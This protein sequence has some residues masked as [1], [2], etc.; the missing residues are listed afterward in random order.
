MPLKNPSPLS[1][2]FFH[3]EWCLWHGTS[4]MFSR[5]LPVGKWVQPPAGAGMADSPE[6]KRHILS[7]LQVSRLTSK[8]DFVS[9]AMATKHDVKRVAIREWDVHQGNGTQSWKRCQANAVMW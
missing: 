8:L 5:F 6:S 4:G 2:I 3:D 9:A 1:T 7:L